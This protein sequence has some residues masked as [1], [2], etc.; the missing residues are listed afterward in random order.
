MSLK[1]II[2]GGEHSASIG[3]IKALTDRYEKLTVIHLDAHRDLAFDFVGEKYS[4]AT[5]MRRAHEMGAN[6]VQIGIRSSSK[7]EEEFVKSTYDIQTFRN[8]DVHKHMDAIEYYLVNIDGPIYISIDMDA[9][10]PSIAPS[11]GNPTPGG[12]FISEVE[13]I[14]ETLS[15][16]NIVGLD[17]VETASSTLGDNTSVVAAKIIYDFLTLIE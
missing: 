12:L 9:V 14:I 7:E 2:I 15:H 17:V 11:V 5:V 10:D 3:A 16:K 8:R 1:P 4:H 13:T 6:L